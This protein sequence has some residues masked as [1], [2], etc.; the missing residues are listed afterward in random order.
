VLQK[1]ESDC[2]CET[3]MSIIRFS[4]MQHFLGQYTRS[5]NFKFIEADKFHDD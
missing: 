3:N 4:Y 1:E 5:K 2:T